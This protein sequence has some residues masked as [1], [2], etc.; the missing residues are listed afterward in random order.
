METWAESKQWTT[1]GT[2]REG[3]VVTWRVS[4][5]TRVLF[6]GAA[7][8]ESGVGSLNSDFTREG[9]TL[10][11]L[12]CIKIVVCSGFGNSCVNGFHYHM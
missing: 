1:N 4:M 6:G 5:V 11:L 7:E 10:V 2:A 8:S 12:G 3:N 9:P